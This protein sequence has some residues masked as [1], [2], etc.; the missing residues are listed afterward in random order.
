ML[1]KIIEAQPGVY[2]VS[3]IPDSLKKDADV[4]VRD[5]LIK[6]TV[7]DINSARYDVHTV[8]TVMNEQGNR[9]LSFSESSDKFQTLDDAEVKVYNQAGEKV[10]TYS[11]KDMSSI[12]IGEGM[13]PDGKTTYLEV[14]APFYPITVE[15]NYTIKF[16]GSLYLPGYSFQSSWQSVQQGVFEMEAPAD[17]GIRYKLLNANYQPVVSH[18]NSKDY[19]RW[20]IKNL[21]AFKPEKYCGSEYNYLPR[22]MVAPNKFQM[23]EYKGDM[24]TWKGFGEWNKKLYDETSRLAEGK[25]LFYREMVKNANTDKEKAAILYNYMQQN[26]RYVSIQL[27]IGG[28][29]PFPASFVDEKKYGDCKALSNYLKSVLDA[30]GVKANMVIINAGFRPRIVYEDFPANYFNHVILCI[31]QPKDTV[32]LE[33]TSRT[34]PFGYLSPFTE[35]RKAV[36]VTENGG[37]LVNTPVSRHTDNKIS[38]YTSITLDKDAFA[39]VTVK[40]ITTGEER[41]NMIASVQEMKE[42]EKR[43]YFIKHFDWKQ[44]DE[45]LVTTAS[46]RPD[47]FVMEAKMSYEKV[48]SFKAGSKYFLSNRLYQLLDEDIPDNPVRRYNYHFDY[49]YVINDTTVYQLPEN[50]SFETIPQNSSVTFPFASF[51]NQYLLDKTANKLS[52]VATLQIKQR[53]VKAADYHKLLEFK[54]VVTESLNEKIVVKKA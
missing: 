31:P 24:S 6:L 33:C 52:I 3:V 41:D 25:K 38:F 26:M 34:L 23:D 10:K 15:Y 13:V 12:S 40:Q 45:I 36:M 28:W 39:D 4:I 30:V 22:L 20:E 17:I 18:N 35:N 27:G 46:G 29:R 21:P 7:K 1:P 51:T 53:I 9:Y 14:N 43:K 42:D 50:F 54:K 32:W 37:V 19:Y 8:I 48:Y 11:K 44:P 2:A 47:P 49:P 16:K 5:E